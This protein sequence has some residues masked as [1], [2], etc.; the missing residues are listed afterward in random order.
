[1]KICILPFPSEFYV[2]ASG[3]THLAPFCLIREWKRAFS[4]SRW[5]GLTLTSKENYTECILVSQLVGFLTVV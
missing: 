5:N 1:M 3:Y 2:L 4:K